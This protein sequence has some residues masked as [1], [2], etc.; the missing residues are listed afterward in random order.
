M[1]PYFPDIEGTRK[2][3]TEYPGVTQITESSLNDNEFLYSENTYNG[4]TAGIIY[5]TTIGDCY[6]LKLSTIGN[7]QEFDSIWDLLKRS[8]VIVP[9]K[10]Y[11]RYGGKTAAD[12]NRRWIDLKTNPNAANPTWQELLDFLRTCQVDQIPFNPPSFSCADYAEALY[13]DSEAA[14]I[15]TAFVAVHFYDSSIGHSLNAYQTTDRGLVFIDATQT[16]TFQSE[17][18]IVDLKVGKAYL[19]RGPLPGEQ[20]IYMN[21]EKYGKVKDFFVIW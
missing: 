14:G 6:L 4:L 16:T 20:R 17:Y 1:P 2:M 9:S 18:K 5:V 3:L 8:L 15:R 19:P 10:H 12:E 21:W 11:A 7:Y 13:N